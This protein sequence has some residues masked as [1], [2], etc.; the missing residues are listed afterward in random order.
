MSEDAKNMFAAAVGA[1]L[2]LLVIPESRHVGFGWILGLIAGYL[3]C[4]IRAE[5]DSHD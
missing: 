1:G 3:L 2:A 5:R 4:S